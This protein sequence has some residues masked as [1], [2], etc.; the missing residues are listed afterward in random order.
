M[1]RPNL[2]LTPLLAAMAVA[3]ITLAA[4]LA[5]GAGAPAY[6]ITGD[7][8]FIGDRA[9]TTGFIFTAQSD[10]SLTA[11]GFH[12]YLLDGLNVAHEVALYGTDGSLLA[13]TTVAA[14][15]SSPL[16][17]EYRY[18]MLASAF[19]LQSGTEYVLAAH[20]D[21]SDGY[22]YATVPPASLSVN[23]LIAIGPNAGVY[24]YG[25]SLSFPSSHAG[26]DIYGTPN[27]LLTPVPEPG[28]WAL[29]C[30]GLAALAGQARR[31]RD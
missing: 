4:P 5:R 30:A 15:T 11:L 8:T 21:S 3:A 24:T 23:P 17:G 14:G 16:I 18:A 25:P 27:M 13:M 6:A 20:S 9:A 1:T 31:R 19:T 7:A 29:A 2:R 12:D 10:A 26:Y 28:T 22:R